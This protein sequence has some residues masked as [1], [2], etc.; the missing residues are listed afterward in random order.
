MSLFTR[1]RLIAAAP[2]AGL[3][4]G[5]A[6]TLGPS[7]AAAAASGMVELVTPFRLQDSR[8]NEP[9]KYDTSAQDNIAVPGLAGHGGVILNVTVTE[10]EGAGFFR[11]AEGFEAV[12]STSTINWY[13]AG[14]TVANLAIVKVTPPAA[15]IS[16]QG[17]GNGRA[18]L[19]LDVLGFVA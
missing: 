11:I 4:A 7:P 6:L 18:H 14:Q 10:T 1:R 9:T 19:I 16:I 3:A 8:V 5:T 15:G 12:P 17:G 2:V 13:T